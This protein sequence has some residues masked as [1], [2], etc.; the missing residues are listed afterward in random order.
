MHDSQIGKYTTVA[1][2]ADILGRV[3]ISE[4]C[5]IGANS[6]ILLEK[7]IEKKAIIGAEAVVTKDVK[8]YAMVIGV[9]ASIMK[10]SI[11]E[12]K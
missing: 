6:T 7:E 2:N 9:P 3:K 4:L 8:G 10:N 12:S 5:Y 11:A 1:P